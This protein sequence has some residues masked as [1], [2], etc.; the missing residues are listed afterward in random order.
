M[1]Y[2]GEWLIP[3]RVISVKMWGVVTM[4]DLDRHNELCLTLI[5]EVQRETPG[6]KLHMLL[7]VIEVDTLPPLYLMPA[8]ALPV[9]RFRKLFGLMCV[10]SQNDTLKN[11]MNLT[12]HVMHFQVRVF[13][14]K[15]A[16]LQTIETLLIK[17]SYPLTK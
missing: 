3:Q 10:L 16:A 9:L 5:D 13:S 7:D 4:G 11:I 6:R 8:K 15:Q 12:A 2:H 1:P 14:E 17:D